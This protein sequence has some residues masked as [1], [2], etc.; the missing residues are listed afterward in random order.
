MKVLVTLGTTP[1]DELLNAILALGIDDEHDLVVQSKHYDMSKF[2]NGFAF[3]DK[4][5]DWY[6]WADVIITHAG[7]GSVYRNLEAGRKLIVVP[8]LSR[9]DKHQLELANYVNEQKYAQVCYEFTQLPDLISKAADYQY[10]VYNN[11]SFTGVKDIIKL[12]FPGQ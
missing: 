5:E 12:F 10:H 9:K 1:F 4:I 8:N 2:K 6:I 7:A 11:D 3:S